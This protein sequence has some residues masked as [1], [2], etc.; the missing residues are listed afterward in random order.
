[1]KAAI[2]HCPVSLSQQ[3]S[4]PSLAE[5]KATFAN[6]EYIRQRLCPQPG[7]Q[8]YLCLA[9]LILALRR[10]ETYDALT[11]LDYGAGASPYRSL[12]PNSQYRRADIA[13]F[14]DPEY[15]IM[16]SGTVPEKSNVFD[17][18]LS[19]QV[20]EHVNNP[21]TYLS[22]CF[23]LLKPDGKLVL[24]T[25]GLFED[26]GCPYDFQRWTADG[27]KRDLEKAGFKIINVDKLTTGPRAIMFLIDRNLDTTSLSR[28]SLPGLLHWTCKTIIRRFR[29]RI[30]TLLDRYSLGCR[31]VSSEIPNQN[32]YLVLFACARRP[33]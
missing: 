5:L 8:H 4:T 17:L 24:I 7:D 28:K 2:D 1:M 21:D 33:Q 31:I 9:D 30:H 20:L 10:V 13:A 25:H 14:E 29:H 15:I 18:V 12:F 23:R 6:K 19:T 26:H 16:G 11:I 27:L 22:E 32:F 3:M